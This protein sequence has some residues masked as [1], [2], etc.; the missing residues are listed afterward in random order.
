VDSKY[1]HLCREQLLCDIYASLQ[2]AAAREW[3]D[4]FATRSAPKFGVSAEVIAKR[5]RIEKHW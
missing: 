3:G 1:D 2:H 4:Y 5:L